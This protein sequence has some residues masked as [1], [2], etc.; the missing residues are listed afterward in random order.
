MP[1]ALDTLPEC[2]EQEPNDSPAAA[3]RVSLPVIVNG[4]IDRPGDWDVFSF[5]GH[6]GQEI[7]GRGLGPPARLAA[8]FGAQTDR[9]Q[10]AGNWPSTTIMKTRAA[11]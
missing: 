6:A 11:A 10:P 5:E 4:R 8:G 7:V 3:Q 9:R 2:L 1:F